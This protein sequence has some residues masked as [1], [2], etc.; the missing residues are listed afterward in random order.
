[1]EII[2]RD[3]KLF[4]RM[5][6]GG[7]LKISE[8]KI[9]IKLAHM[10]ALPGIYKINDSESGKSYIGSSFNLKQRCVS[11]FYN[12]S[13][14]I[15]RPQFENVKYDNLTFEVLHII[16]NATQDALWIN[17]RS[18][19]IEQNTLFPNGFNMNLPMIGSIQNINRLKNKKK[20]KQKPKPPKYKVMCFVNIL[21]D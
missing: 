15:G 7:L 6:N 19:I 12:T 8:K 3:G 10:P 9:Y 16:E 18:A 2:N 1:M 21:T 13:A 11:Y 14:G 20:S 4:R 17:E 5:P